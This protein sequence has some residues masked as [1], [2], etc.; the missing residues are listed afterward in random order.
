MAKLLHRADHVVYQSE[1]CKLSAD[2]FLGERREAWEVLHNPVDT[3]RFTPGDKRNA[4]H[5]LL[6]GGNQYQRYRFATALETLA[7][8]PSDWRLLVTGELSWEPNR[9]RS[10]RE[11]RAMVEALGLSDRVELTGPYTQTE[12]P[13]LMRSASL[14]LHTKYND[15]CPTIVLEAMACGLPVVYSASGGTPELVGPDAGIGVPASLDWEQD[16]PPDPDLLATAVREV[17]E[18]L[19]E[20]AEAARSRAEKFDVRPWLERHRRLFEELV[21]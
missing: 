8:L 9:S 18:R 19:P 4:G 10:R 7:R 14:L 3:A 5:V 21:S 11:G 17:S 20:H 6:L 13:P 16:H 15:P 12:A 1:F 2:Q